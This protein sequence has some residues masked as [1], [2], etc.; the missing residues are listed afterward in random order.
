MEIVLFRSLKPLELC[1]A[2]PATISVAIFGK[3]TLKLTLLNGKVALIV[4]F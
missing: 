2:M 4:L 1:I 3:V